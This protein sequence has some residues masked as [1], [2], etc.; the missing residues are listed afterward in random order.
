MPAARTLTTTE[1]HAVLRNLPD[2]TT[3]VQVID[4]KGKQAWRKPDDVVNTDNLVFGN[5]GPV[6]MKGTPGRKAA[7]K[8]APV[9]D[10]IAEIVEAKEH[11][12]ENDPLTALVRADPDQ[13]DVLDMVMQELA[14]EA[15]SLE[16][17]RK[18]AER[19]GNDTSTYSLRRAR[20]LQAVG[21]M[22]LQRKK[23][24]DSGGVDL[25]SKGFE[26]VFGFALETFREAMGESGVRPELIETTFAKLGKVLES[27]W[28]EEAKI[29]AR[30]AK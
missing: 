27:G 23:L 24:A 4:E 26:A 9:N 7:P 19:L 25:E 15:S 2:G 17:E 12:L 20:I 1:K 6:V 13:G 16:F 11:H 21:D 29:L 30:T 28:K 8:L 22:H 5:N 3:R 10:N 18:E 14:K